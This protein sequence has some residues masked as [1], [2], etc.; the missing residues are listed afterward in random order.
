MKNIEAYY[1]AKL[2]LLYASCGMAAVLLIYET[3]RGIAQSV[4]IRRAAKKSERS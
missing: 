1:L 4:R 3:A 2:I